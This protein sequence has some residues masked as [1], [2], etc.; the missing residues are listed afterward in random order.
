VAALAPQSSARVREVLGLTSTSRVVLIATDTY[1]G[2][3]APHP[4]T[5]YDV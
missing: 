3:T 5:F 1:Q 4:K 2:R